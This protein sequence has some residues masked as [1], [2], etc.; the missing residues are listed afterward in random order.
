MVE[1][2]FLEELT[3]QHYHHCLVSGLPVLCFSS[4]SSHVS[5]PTQALDCEETYVQLFWP[6]TVLRKLTSSTFGMVAEMV[7][8]R[9]PAL[10]RLLVFPEV[11][12]R[13]IV[14]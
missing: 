2:F 4:S 1:A 8:S 11:L 12:Q 10:P 13:V 7:K 5:L 14:D 9:M 3:L 6:V